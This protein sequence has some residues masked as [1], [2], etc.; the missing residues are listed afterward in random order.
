MQDDK[1]KWNVI[2]SHV[3]SELRSLAHAWLL[4]GYTPKFTYEFKIKL[5]AYPDGFL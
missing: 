4:V 1:L 2:R 3:Q 5:K